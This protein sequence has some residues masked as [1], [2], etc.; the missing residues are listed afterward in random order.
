MH[1]LECPDC[2]EIGWGLVEAKEEDVVL[3]LG[4]KGCRRT[5]KMYCTMCDNEVTTTYGTEEAY[6]K[7]LWTLQSEQYRWELQCSVRR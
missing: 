1:N 7:A 3:P 4:R 6:F 2:E 5:I